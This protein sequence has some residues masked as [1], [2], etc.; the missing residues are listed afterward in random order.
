[1]L[2]CIHTAAILYA[3][4]KLH[5]M[6]SYPTMCR[7][8]S[9]AL[10]R[11]LSQTSANALDVSYNQC[12]ILAFA[13]CLPVWSDRVHVTSSQLGLGSRHI[14]SSSSSSTTMQLPVMYQLPCSTQQQQQSWAAVVQQ[15][16][17]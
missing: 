6:I 14:S 7:L 3:A 12:L 10:R 16:P 8:L 11:A 4:A 2:R 9:V 17:L 5:Y 15:M 13:G 1:M